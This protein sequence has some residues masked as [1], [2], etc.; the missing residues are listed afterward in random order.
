MIRRMDK[1]PFV[2]MGLFVGAA[3]SLVFASRTS[4]LTLVI[5][6][7]LLVMIVVAYLGGPAAYILVTQTHVIVGNPL[8]EYTVPRVL[9]DGIQSYGRPD[10][11]LRVR[12]HDPV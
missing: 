11:K 8:V 1:L 6:P 9:T 12:G 5:L 4:A 10:I 7:I 3:V 2:V